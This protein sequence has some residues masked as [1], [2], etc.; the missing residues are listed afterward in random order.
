MKIE[1]LADHTDAIPM[2]ARWAYE[3][4][5]YLHPDRTYAEVEALISEGCNKDVIPISLVAMDAGK[6]V[7][8]AALKASDF[9]ARPNLGPWLGGLYV[10]KRQRRKGVGSRLVG[11]IEKLAA[12][13]GVKKL[14]LVTDGAEKLYSD[15]GWSV[16]ER[17]RSKGVAT[18]VMEKSLPAA[19]A[20]GDR[21]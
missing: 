20:S 9:K 13:H 17:V 8:W 6:V 19:G 21:S 1:F 5:A 10:D 2:L 3:E 7:G 14:F 16:R 11:E 18:V 4:W 12:R 15:L